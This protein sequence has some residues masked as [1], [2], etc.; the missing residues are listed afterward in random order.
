MTKLY[1]LTDENR[2][3]RA[4]EANELQ[5]GEG[6]T[7]TAKGEGTKLCTDGVIHAYEDP[8][9]ALFMNPIYTAFEHPRLWEAEGEIVVR[10]GLK[11]GCK[12]LT[13]VREIPIPELTLTQYVRFAILCALEL[14]KEEGFVQWAHKWLSGEDRSEESAKAAAQTAASKIARN[15]A[16]AARAEAATWAHAAADAAAVWAA[17]AIEMAVLAEGSQILL[18]AQ[19]A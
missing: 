3:T 6:V 19:G 5:W 12:I 8:L 4:G 1:K 16:W 13:T 7:H 14:H 11:V 2:K 18:L 10:D 9:I 17:E 15:A